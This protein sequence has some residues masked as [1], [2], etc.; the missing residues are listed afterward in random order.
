MNFRVPYK[1]A[2]LLASQEKLSFVGAVSWK[3][4]GTV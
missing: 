4:M 1:A 3:Q 2:E